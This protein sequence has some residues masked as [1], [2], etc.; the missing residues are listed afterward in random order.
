MMMMMMM[1]I[2]IKYCSVD[3]PTQ[4]KYIKQTNNP[5]TDTRQK[6]DK[7][8]AYPG[9]TLMLIEVMTAKCDVQNI[10][11]IWKLYPTTLLENKYTPDPGWIL[12]KCVM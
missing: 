2:Q 9:K 6:L 1:M 10:K 8:K 7:Y 3:T 12:W 11:Q 4:T 5:Q